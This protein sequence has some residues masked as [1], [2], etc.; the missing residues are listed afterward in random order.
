MNLDSADPLRG[1]SLVP[2]NG[3]TRDQL[4]RVLAGEGFRGAHRSGAFL[5]YIVTCALAGERQRLGGY[6]IGVEVFERGE[7]FD[8]QAD[9]IVRVE[10]GRLR[11]RLERYYLTE[12][13]DDPITVHRVI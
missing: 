2:S 1:S 6:S 5:E 13:K 10:A 12:G 4:D 11:R 3:E 7:D 9:P 8:A